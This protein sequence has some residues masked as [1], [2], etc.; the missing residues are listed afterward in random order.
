MQGHK[1][2][3]SYKTGKTYIHM[4]KRKKHAKYKG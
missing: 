3:D 4:K 1:A 2:K